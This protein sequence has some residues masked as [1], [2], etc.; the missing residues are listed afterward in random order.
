M[1]RCRESIAIRL[2]VDRNINNANLIVIGT[3]VRNLSDIAIKV[4]D[5]DVRDGISST[6]ISLTG[7]V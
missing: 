5:A 1:Q 4:P 3:Q 6:A 2:F 7:R